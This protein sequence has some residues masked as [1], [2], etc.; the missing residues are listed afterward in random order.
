MINEIGEKTIVWQLT[1]MDHRIGREWLAHYRFLLCFIE[2]ANNDFFLFW[3]IDRK[4]R[5]SNFRWTKC[6]FHWTKSNL[7][8]EKRI[9]TIYVTNSTWNPSNSDQ[10]H[11]KTSKLCKLMHW[12]ILKKTSDEP[13]EKENRRENLIQ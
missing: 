10:F 4:F 9:C 8:S 5:M 13:S 6:N 12:S 11:R 7:S 2:P 3:L 1:R